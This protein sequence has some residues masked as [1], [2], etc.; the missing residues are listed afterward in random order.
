V[1]T[2]RFTMLVT[3]QVDLFSAALEAKPQ[4]CESTQALFRA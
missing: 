2:S 3:A 1:I 4:N